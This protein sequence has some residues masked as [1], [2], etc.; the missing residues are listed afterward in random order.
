MTTKAFFVTI[1]CVGLVANLFGQ[2][3][4][5]DAPLMMTQISVHCGVQVPAG[6]MAQKYNT[7]FSIGGSLNL[8]TTKNFI[9][10]LDYSYFFNEQVKNPDQYLLN[11]RTEDNIIIAKDGNAANILGSER[12]HIA[13]ITIGKIFPIIGPNP[14]SGIIVKIGGGYLQHKLNLEARKQDV[15]QIE[16]EMRKYYDQLTSGP[17]I[18]EFIG[19]QHN[20]N[21]RLANFYIGIEGYQAFTKNRRDYNIDLGGP[22][23]TQRLDMLFGL[24]VGWMWL[25]YKR[26]PQDFYFN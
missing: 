5:D 7:S 2:E 11:L 1:I 10:G 13:Q 3:N 8:K 16:D 6:M 9:F 14:N 17:T 21:S 19:Y 25:I 15:P 4:I 24:K 23:N 22:D 12:G 26:K 18:S 20:S